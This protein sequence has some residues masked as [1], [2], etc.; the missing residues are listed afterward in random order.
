MTCK[1]KRL[2][3]VINAN[4]EIEE[5]L[6]EKTGHYTYDYSSLSLEHDTVEMQVV[7]CRDCKKD[8]QDEY[9]KLQS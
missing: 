1:H 9:D 5:N 2:S 8:L 6:D 7:A 4:I 3:L